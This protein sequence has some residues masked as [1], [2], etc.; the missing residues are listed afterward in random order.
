MS[1]RKFILFI[2]AIALLLAGSF[3]GYVYANPSQ[4]LRS[5][6]TDNCGV[7]VATTSVTYL[8]PGV[9]TSTPTFDTQC[10]GGL[11]V[12]SASLLVYFNASSTG[13][14]LVINFEYSDNGT[15]WFSNSLND[16]STSTPNNLNLNNALTWNFSSSTVGKGGQANADGRNYDSKIV[17]VKTPTRYVRAIIGMPGGSLN[18]AVWTEFVAKKQSR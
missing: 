3:G 7:P 11:S 12:D 6:A 5:Y 4:F 15:D 18:G 17:N 1:D 16:V 9:S 8:T 2:G 13:S 10:D 14:T